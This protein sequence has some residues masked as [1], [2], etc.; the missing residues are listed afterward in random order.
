MERKFKDGPLQGLH[1][2]VST[3]TIHTIPLL[4]NVGQYSL[5]LKKRLNVK[6]V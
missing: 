3:V 5:T 4:E 2:V 6:K 1:L